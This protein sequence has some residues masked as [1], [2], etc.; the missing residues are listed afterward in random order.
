[1]K[2][3]AAILLLLALVPALAARAA[4]PELAVGQEWSIRASP[5]TPAKVI[6]GKID[7]LEDG[8]VAVSISLIDVPGARGPV[9]VGHAPF[10]EAALAASVDQLLATGQPSPPQFAE[11]YR[12]WRADPEGGLFTISV[13]DVLTSFADEMHAVR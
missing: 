6:I 8:T 7:T 9:T 2:R 5:P 4:P 10:L 12:R 13:A 3:L 1:M 11:A